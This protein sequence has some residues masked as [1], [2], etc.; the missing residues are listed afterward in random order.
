MWKNAHFPDLTPVL[1][2]RLPATAAT[3]EAARW[4]RPPK[5]SRPFSGEG[6]K[7]LQ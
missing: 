6:P 3:R 5:P 7:S 2:D 4:S 1:G